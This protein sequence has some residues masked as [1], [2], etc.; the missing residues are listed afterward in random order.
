M[1]LQRIA[2]P[3][4]STVSP[5][6]TANRKHSI[7]PTPSPGASPAPRSLKLARAP[8][9]RF[10][11]AT[12]TTRHR[13]RL[14]EA[15]TLLL[16]EISPQPRN[17]APRRLRSCLRAAMRYPILLSIFFLVK[18][19]FASH[20]AMDLLLLNRIAHPSYYIKEYSVLSPMSLTLTRQAHIRPRSHSFGMA[21]WMDIPSRQNYPLNSSGQ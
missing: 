11:G 10:R 9:A 14:R 4:P 3:A 7:R 16:L 12:R 2:P 18:P 19:R 13:V 8:M 15:A 20:S 5:C 1:T 21:T 17:Q 6:S